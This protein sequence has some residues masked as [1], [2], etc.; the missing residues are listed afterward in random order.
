MTKGKPNDSTCYKKQVSQYYI[1]RWK[2]R[3]PNCSLDT[4]PPLKDP[5]KME[6]VKLDKKEMAQTGVHPITVSVLCGT[7]FGDASLDRSKG[8]PRIQMRHST[9]Q[10][11]WFFWKCFCGLQGYVQE[12]SVSFELPDG[13]QS[14]SPPI[15]G[16]LLG[17]LHTATLRQ[18]ELATLLDI[19]AKPH[20]EIKR[21]W[22]NHMNA[23]FLM[24][25]WLDDGS[26]VSYNSEGEWCLNS[27]PLDQAE[28]LVDYFETVW[29][30]KCQALIVPSR[31][32]KTNPNPVSITFV[33]QD[34]L[35]IF[36]RI[37]A[38]LVP[39]ESM[40][41]KVCFCPI[42][43]SRQQRWASELK[44]LVRTEWHPTI[45]AILNYNLAARAAIKCFPRS[46]GDN[47]ESSD[48][49]TK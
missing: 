5:P 45:D 2:E 8:K 37:I 14:A 29:G 16:E 41:Y 43:R 47:S 22:L 46:V 10:S 33:D 39:V 38:P 3:Y 17:K 12:T 15:G 11:E 4:L 49:T 6:N 42:D 18:P 48:V 27:T 31:V 20:K 40:L 7:L 25:L 36:L 26:L 21:S 44:T 1:R 30:F 34:Q 23:Y 19:V 35:E 28:I 13:Y 24:T 9:R 32:T